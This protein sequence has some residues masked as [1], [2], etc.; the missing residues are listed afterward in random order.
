MESSRKPASE[1]WSA[2]SNL[3]VS[4]VSGA[5]SAAPAAPPEQTDRTGV[6][7]TPSSVKKTS[8]SFIL[9]DQAVTEAAISSTRRGSRSTHCVCA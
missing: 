5:A 4:P 9:D 1:N 6:A 3:R 8:L 2:L 7:G